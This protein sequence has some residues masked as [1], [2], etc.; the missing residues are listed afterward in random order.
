[1]SR[2]GLPWGGTIWNE[3]LGRKLA[4]AA[5]HLVPDGAPCGRRSPRAT[6]RAWLAEEKKAHYIAVVKRNQPLLHARVKALPWRQVPAAR[7]IAASP[8]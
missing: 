7:E 2:R 5:R 8:S 6:G 1:M 3:G 4:I